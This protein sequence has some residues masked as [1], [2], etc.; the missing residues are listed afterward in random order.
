VLEGALDRLAFID[1]ETLLLTLRHGVTGDD[2]AAVLGLSARRSN[3]Q[4]VRAWQLAE[5]AVSAEVLS[6]CHRC[7]GN[8]SSDEPAI[9]APDGVQPIDDL[10]RLA[11]HAAACPA[12]LRRAEMTA[13]TLLGVPPT[14]V[15]PAGLRH[16]VMHTGT[17]QELAGYRA[18]IAARGGHLNAD[19]L[20]HQPDVPSPVARRWIFT[21]GGV[22]GAL[23]SALVAAFIIGPGL[24]SS[25]IEW[26]WHHL[27][28][29]SGPTPSKG[30][31]VHQPVRPPA[32]Q[33]DRPPP[34]YPAETI[35]PQLDGHPT[36]HIPTPK[37]T[38]WDSPVPQA[39]GQ[40]VVG[41]VAVTLGIGQ[42][43]YVEL[44]AQNGPVTWNAVTS[45]GQLE[46]DSQQGVIPAA[47]TYQLRISLNRLLVQLPGRAVITLTGSDGQPQNVEVSWGLSLLHS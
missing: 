32:D 12:C 24:P 41:P 5:S 17:D 42:V 35:V 45:T 9:E 23:V 21:G 22:V 4:A 7:V 31:E 44:S 37:G 16:R 1:Q 33:K 14:P 3:A 6:E 46:L 2:L 15:V 36:P 18:E 28:I 13:S 30:R 29:E 40:L 10:D 8:E 19:G 43:A 47:G 25:D 39:S 11:E 27:P 26:P 20:P 34:A 38:P